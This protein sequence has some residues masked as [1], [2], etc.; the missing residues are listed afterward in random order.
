MRAV[1]EDFAALV[2]R[3]A[4]TLHCAARPFASERWTPYTG[5]PG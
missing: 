5:E 1:F 3:L 4:T 2:P